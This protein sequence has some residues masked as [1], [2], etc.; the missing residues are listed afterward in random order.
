MGDWRKA[1]RARSSRATLEH[2]SRDFGV[3]A[4]S[5]P[6]TT[7]AA[8]RP[9]RR[10]QTSHPAGSAYVSDGRRRKTPLRTP[11]IAKRVEPPEACTQIPDEDFASDRASRSQSAS[12]PN[13]RFILPSEHEADGCGLPASSSGQRRTDTAARCCGSPYPAQNRQRK[14]GLSERRRVPRGDSD[15]RTAERCF[16]W[17]TLAGL[18]SRIQAEEAQTQSARPAGPSA[19]HSKVCKPSRPAAAHDERRRPM[20]R[21]HPSFG[22]KCAHLVIGATPVASPRELSNP[23]QSTKR[24]LS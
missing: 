18:S 16:Q 19:L 17:A 23:T 8:I 7:R 15:G 11:D 20:E 5:S 4:V 21:S 12:L 3:R 6:Y 22:A 14:N 10:L 1:R 13:L 2:A 9:D 24:A